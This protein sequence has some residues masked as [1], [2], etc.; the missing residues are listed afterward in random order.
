[1]IIVNCSLAAAEHLYK[2]FKKGSNEGFFEPATTQSLAET[3]AEREKANKPCFQWVVHAIKL[4]RSTC[5][6]AVEFETRYCHVIHQVKKG[7]M[8][9]FLSRLQ[10]R[11]MN[12]LEW[13]GQDYLLFDSVQMVQGIERY[14]SLHKNIRFYQRTDRSVISH[15]SQIAAEYSDVYHNNGCFP[16]DE[17]TALEFDLKLNQTWRTRKGEK[18]DLHANEKMIQQWLTEYL[19][20][21]SQNVTDA[22]AQMR[23]V[24]QEQWKIR[25]AAMA[26]TR[27]QLDNAN[28]VDVDGHDNVIELSRYQQRKK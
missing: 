26:A 20:F 2:G 25:L 14:F 24:Q 3:K 13:Q 22:M 15:I 8:Q 1:M 6:I 5:L 7:N 11:L 17:E 16:P 27:Q 10:E 21:A 28:I 9:D 18:Y 12:G 23:A 19:C 4:G